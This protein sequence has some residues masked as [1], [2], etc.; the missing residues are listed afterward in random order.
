MFKAPKRQKFS[1]PNFNDRAGGQAPSAIILH[2]TGMKDAD[3]ALSR[4]CDPEAKVSAHYVIEENGRAHHLVDEAQRAWHAGVSFWNGETDI[5]SASVGIELVNPGHEFGYRAFPARQIKVLCALLQDLIQRHPIPAHRILGHS[6]IAPAR[7][8]DPGELFP[9]MELAAQGLGLWPHPEE[10]DYQAA[11]DLI[12]RPDDIRALLVDYG[13][14]PQVDYQTLVRA[15]HRHFYPE[16]FGAGNDPLTP[17]I[18]SIARLLSL[19]RQRHA[20]KT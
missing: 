16:K 8:D 13:Y 10:M 15:F 1:S 4:L 3:S 6:D 11:E 19:I 17:D 9:W 5:N 7:K 12:L 14:D 18:A 20:Q 2:Y